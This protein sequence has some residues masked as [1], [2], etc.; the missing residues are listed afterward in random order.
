MHHDTTLIARVAMGF[1]LACAFGYLAA[2]VRLPPIVGY[3]VAA[4]RKT[5]PNKKGGAC[6]PPLPVNRQ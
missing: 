2:R 5:W 3:L 1:V 6:A 4:L